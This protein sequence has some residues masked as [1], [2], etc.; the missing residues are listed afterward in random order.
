MAYLLT[1]ASGWRDLLSV[2]KSFATSNGWTSVYDQIAAKGQLGLSKGNCHVSLGATRNSGD[3]ADANTFS[4]TDAVFGGT[5]PDAEINLALATALVA[6]TTRYWGHTG[7]LV[8]SATDSD[9]VVVNDLAAATFTNVWLFSPADNNAIHVVVQS[10]AERYTHFSF[11]QL[12]VKGLNQ[13]RCGYAVGSNH[14][15]W[16]D[17]TDY[18]QNISA[19]FNYVQGSHTWGMLGQSNALNVMIPSGLL[20]TSYTWGVTAPVCIGLSAPTIY[21]LMNIGDQPSDHTTQG[22][23]GRMLD[24]FM[25]V[26]N[27]QT[28]GGIPLHPFTFIL[29]NGTSDTGISAW[30]GEIPD[31][32]LVNMAGL[33]P[34]QEIKYASDIWTV[35]PWKQKGTFEDSNFGTNAQPVCNTQDYGMAFKK[36]V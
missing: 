26:N 31:V 30:L 29:E 5:V 14:T 19:D 18:T 21:T 32:R 10:A 3:T 12:D 24:F 4:R 23:A 25:A 13:P 36:N 6:G 2:I 8:T 20:N 27:V 35:F 17:S 28:T 7:S 16:P 9:R 15:W 33:A 1:S 34:G 11:G 22:S